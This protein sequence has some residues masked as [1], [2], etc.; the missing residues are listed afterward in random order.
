[1]FS[2]DGEI[3]VDERLI[4]DVVK[5][6]IGE[7]TLT[8]ELNTQKTKSRLANFTLKE[9]SPIARISLNR[10]SSSTR[11]VPVRNKVSPRLTLKTPVEK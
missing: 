1:M 4:N 9:N 5:Q 3:R 10:N 2:R 11:T 6:P 7:P 8:D